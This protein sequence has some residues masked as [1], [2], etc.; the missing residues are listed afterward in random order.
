M[1]DLTLARLASTWR[2]E[3]LDLQSV[4]E[5]EGWICAVLREEAYHPGLIA[6]RAKKAS[7]LLRPVIDVLSDGRIVTRQHFVQL[8]YQFDEH[9]QFVQLGSLTHPLCLAES[10][11]FDAETNRNERDLWESPTAAPGGALLFPLIGEESVAILGWAEFRGVS[12]TVASDPSFSVL[13]A[14][15]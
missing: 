1:S 11:Y 5:G 10:E 6:D 8:C 15:R 4:S 13:K 14:D 12:V 2:E 3:D 9:H 7:K